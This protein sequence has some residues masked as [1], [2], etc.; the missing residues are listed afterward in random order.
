MHGCTYKLEKIELPNASNI[1]GMNSIKFSLF[2][3]FQN[4]LRNLMVSSSQF[5]LSLPFFSTF[6]EKEIV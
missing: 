6:S 3:L 1:V 5:F 4:I 2:Y